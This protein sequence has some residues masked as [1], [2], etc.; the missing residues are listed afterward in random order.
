MAEPDK[1][2]PETSVSAGRC[3]Y[4]WKAS[5]RKSQPFHLSISHRTFW[6]RL[7][8][9]SPRS[10]ISFSRINGQQYKFIFSHQPRVYCF[11]YY[12][13]AG[14]TH[15]EQSHKSP[16]CLD[17]FRMLSCIDLAGRRATDSTT[18]LSLGHYWLKKLSIYVRRELMST[19]KA[20]ETPFEPTCC[21]HNLRLHSGR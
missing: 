20:C 21:I 15:H 1:P 6:R 8:F 4:S 17:H 11:I 5:S 12:T 3:E 2:R 18:T 9:F 14:N 16:N 13:V 19:T 7:S 10:R